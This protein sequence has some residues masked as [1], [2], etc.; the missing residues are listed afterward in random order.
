MDLR[1]L[2][3]SDLGVSP[4]CLGTTTF[5]TPVGEEDAVRMVHWA[6]D[7]GVNFVDTADIYEGYTRYVGSPGGWLRR[8]RG[9]PSGTGGRG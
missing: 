7:H 8:Y 4:I 5:G 3:N 2:P 1:K 6:L 9:R